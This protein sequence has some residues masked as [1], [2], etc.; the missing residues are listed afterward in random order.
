MSKRDKSDHS[1][2]ES[3]GIG[4]LDEFYRMGEI[5]AYMR[6][7]TKS[8]LLCASMYMLNIA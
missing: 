8:I 1:E 7:L 5:E 4:K 3:N 2:I 6:Y